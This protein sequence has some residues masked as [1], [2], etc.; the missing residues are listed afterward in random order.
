MKSFKDYVG[1]RKITEAEMTTEKP[2]VKLVADYD[3]PTATAPDQG[4]NPVSYKPANAALDPNKGKDET[5]FAN[6]GGKNLVYNPDTKAGDSKSTALGTQL[7][8]NWPKLKSESWFE[9]TKKMNRNE[10]VKFVNECNCSSVKEEELPT[11]TATSTGAI[12]PFPPEAIRY[13][14]ALSTKNP[15]M[16]ENLVHEMKR[17]GNLGALLQ[18]LLEHPESYENLTYLLGD[19]KDGPKRCRLLA[20]SMNEHVGPP[21]GDMGHD[22]EDDREED[23]THKDDQDDDSDMSDDHHDDDDEHD[24]DHDD[25]DDDDDT[26]SSDDEPHDELGNDS[27]DDEN[28]LG[29]GDDDDDETFDNHDD[30]GKDK[31]RNNFGFGKQEHSIA[32][33][34]IF[35]SLKSKHK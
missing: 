23:P 27:D 9:K 30:D 24:D 3:G 12:R 13:V 14:T 15:K 17:A 2:K 16:L 10:F 35:N 6:L 5:G 4:K 32:F 22:D 18:A 28:G 25:N 33:K 11:I 20:R 31:L 29:H 34:D 8:D 1:S 26:D 21:M 7:K 19:E